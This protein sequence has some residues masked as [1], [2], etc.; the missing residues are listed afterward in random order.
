MDRAEARASDWLARRFPG[1]DLVHEPDG[2]VAP[3]FLLDG[4]IAIEVRRLSEHAPGSSPT[5]LIQTGIP[6]QRRLRAI[7]ATVPRHRDRTLLTWVGFRRPLP[8]VRELEAGARPF[9]EQLA[10]APEPV[11]MSCSVSRT[12]ELKCLDVR[13]GGPRQFAFAWIDHNGWGTPIHVLRRN[14]DL[15]IRDKLT[16][17]ESVRHRYPVWWLLLVNELPFNADEC[18]RLGDDEWSTLAA[19]WDDVIVIDWTDDYPVFELARSA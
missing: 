9:L 19:G 5:P 6:F 4:R 2:N 18:E 1:V 16:K 12:A 14:L 10:L 3:D 13:P 7:A 8:T 17:T 15:C 11:G